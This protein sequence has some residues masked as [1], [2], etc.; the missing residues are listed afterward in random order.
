MDVNSTLTSNDLTWA[1]NETLQSG[2]SQRKV[3]NSRGIAQYN[4]YNSISVY[5]NKDLFNGFQ[6]HKKIK[7][8]SLFEKIDGAAYALEIWNWNLT[9]WKLV[10]LKKAN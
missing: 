9:A 1:T 4:M 7:Q 6:K 10:K 8:S 2:W 3:E 5:S